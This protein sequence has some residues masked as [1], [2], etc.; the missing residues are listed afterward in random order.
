MRA[1]ADALMV[2]WRLVTSRLVR[3]VD[4]AGGEVYVWTVDELPRLRALEALG[5]TGVITNDPRLLGRARRL[6]GFGCP[7]P[8]RHD[9]FAPCQSGPGRLSRM[10]QRSFGHAAVVTAAEQFQKTFP[11]R[12]IQ[13]LPPALPRVRRPRGSGSLTRARSP[14]M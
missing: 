10:A 8:S 13:P 4:A 1:N 12:G 6:R 5:V 7:N 11:R 3:A 9:I 14:S 2:H